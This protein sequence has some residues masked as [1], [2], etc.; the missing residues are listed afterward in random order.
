LL[1]LTN[2]HPT[3]WWSSWGGGS[4]SLLLW[5]WTG[6]RNR[7]F[8]RN[9]Y[10]YQYP[11]IEHDKKELL[12]FWRDVCCHALLP[13][14]Q[15]RW[16]AVS[17][18]NEIWILCMVQHLNCCCC[19]CRVVVGVSSTTSNSSSRA[20]AFTFN[21]STIRAKHSD[22]VIL[23]LWLLLFVAPRYHK[24]ALLLSFL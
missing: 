24:T 12:W 13:F 1:L 23:L 22:H 5:Y 21:T 17:A 2:H 11:M 15:C 4:S 7:H 8:Q 16:G 20:A 3:W 19:G 6:T 10:R 14:F 9:S 18:P